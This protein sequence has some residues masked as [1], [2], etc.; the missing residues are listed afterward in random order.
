MRTRITTRVTMGMQASAMVQY[1]RSWGSSQ[2][3]LLAGRDGRGLDGIPIDVGIAGAAPL[4]GQFARVGCFRRASWQRCF[5]CHATGFQSIQDSR[6]A[7]Q[8]GAQGIYLGEW[9]S[10]PTRRCECERNPTPRCR[11][12]PLQLT[13]PIELARSSSLTPTWRRVCSDFICSPF[14]HVCCYHNSD[15]RDLHWNGSR[16][17]LECSSVLQYHNISEARRR[18][19]ARTTIWP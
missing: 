5:T 11:A 2:Y 19:N 6:S 4:R 3:Q 14:C 17:S 8:P 1:L 18:G 16:L 10:W 9:Q 7:S 15:N 13:F 12:C